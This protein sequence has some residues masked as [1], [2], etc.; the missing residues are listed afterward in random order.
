MASEEDDA[1]IEGMNLIKRLDREQQQQQKRMKSWHSA[2]VRVNNQHKAGEEMTEKTKFYIHKLQNNA[3]EHLLH[4]SLYYSL[5][6]LIRVMCVIFTFSAL[7]LALP[8]AASARFPAHA[9]KKSNQQNFFLPNLHELLKPFFHGDGSI[10]PFAQGT[11]GGKLA[12]RPF[13]SWYCVIWK[14]ATAYSQI[15]PFSYTFFTAVRPL[16]AQS[17]WRLSVIYNLHPATWMNINT[18]KAK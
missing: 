7:S 2:N 11:G 9:E 10:S 6:L 3:A 12:P 17:S 14:F 5:R 1:I 18:S 4:R 8:T 15:Y 16:K 13:L